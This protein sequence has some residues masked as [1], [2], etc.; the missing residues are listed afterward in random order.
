M[1]TPGGKP[2]LPSAGS[3]DKRSQALLPWAFLFLWTIL[4]FSGLLLAPRLWTAARSF[5]PGSAALLPWAG[6]MTILVFLTTGLLRS[7]SAPRGRLLLLVAGWAAA[8]GGCTALLSRYPVEPIHAAEYVVLA[9][10]ARWSFKTIVSG[11][12]VWL[13]SFLFASGIGTVEEVLQYWVPGRVYDPRDLVLNGCSV[14]FGLLLAA[15]MEYG[16]SGRISWE[17]KGG[18]K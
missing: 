12:R 14:F 18:G 3:S 13:W 11:N 9:L 10:L 1:K 8:F 5:L 2:P 4:L 16:R 17:T 6:L 15:C 7:A